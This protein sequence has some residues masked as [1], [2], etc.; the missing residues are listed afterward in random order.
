MALALPVRMVVLFTSQ[1]LS[2][3][4]PRLDLTL[5][6]SWTLV[7]PISLYMYSLASRLQQPR[8]SPEARCRHPS[9]AVA[10][11]SRP[12]GNDLSAEAGGSLAQC[13]L[14]NVEWVHPEEE[15][16]AVAAAHPRP[17]THWG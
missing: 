3:L 6:P 5:L 2:M 12:D 14:G 15:G 7:V 16:Q 17:G 1:S 8:S 9:G 4:H 11:R 10:A 13:L